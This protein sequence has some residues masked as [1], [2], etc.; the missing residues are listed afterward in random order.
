MT[1]ARN[2]VV[3]SGSLAILL[4]S[5]PRTVR[6]MNHPKRRIVATIAGLGLVLG[7]QVALGPSPAAAATTL[8]VSTTADIAVN[9]GACGN[10]GTTTAP[11]PLSLREAT[12][13][14]NN[15]GGTVTITIPSGTYVL[16]HGELQVGVHAGQ[17][18][19]LDGTTAATTTISAGG[20][21]RVLDFDP[22][23]AGG[24]GGTVSDLTITGGVD[25]T[26]GGAGIIA[27]SG[28]TASADTLAI[29][30]SVITANHANN[31]GPTITNRPGGGVQFIG[32][33]LTISNSTISNNS[34]LSS[35]G[36]GVAYAGTGAT[37][38]EAL[39]VTNT[40]FSDNSAT[41]TN[42]TSITNGGALDIR[43]AP[44]TQAVI[45]G[46]RFTNN[47]V[48]ATTGGAVGAAIRH[49]SGAL[50][51]TGSTFT[52]NTVNGG[53]APPAGGAI[54]VTTGTATLH[55]NRFV[56][57]TATSGAAVDVGS[58]AGAVDAS[59]NWFGCNAAPSVSGCDSVAGS[60]V[61][62]PRLA[63]T[64]TANPSTVFGPG[65]TSTITAS[66]TTDSLGGAVPSANLAA[67][68]DLTVG[69][70]DP[71]PNGATVNGVLVSTQ[72]TISSG[73]SSVT[74]G[75]QGS[76][77]VG[78]VVATL[79]GGSSTVPV[80]VD[81]AP[82]VTL[83]PSDQAVQPGDPVSFTAAGTGFPTPTVKWQRSVDGGTNFTDI[84]S[85]TSTTYSFT[86]AA[87]DSG[88]RYRAL[89]TNVTDISRTATST[90]ATLTVQQPPSF[91]SATTAT[92]VTGTAGSFTI[93]T[94]GQPTVSAITKTGSLPSGLAFTDNGNGTATV[95]GTPA[96]NTGGTYPLGLT[97]VNGVAPAGTQSLA[98]Q[99][100]QAPA[101]TGNPS[102]QLVNPGTPVS[103]TAA[104]TGVPTPT[105][106]WQ[107]S[108]DGGSSY[109]N[110]AGATSATYS[111]T[112]TS[113]DSG[114]RYRAVFTNVV[115]TATSTAALLQ[116][117]SAPAFTSENVATF[118]V[119]VAGSFAITT[120]G[121]PSA[122]L[123][124]VGT[125]PA[126]LTLADNGDGTATLTGTPP[127]GSGG[128]YTFT[129]KAAN[130]FSP[131]ASQT[132]TLSVDESPTITSADNVTFTVG[133]AGTFAV[134]TTAGF[135]TATAI[136]K[137]GAL[138]S[139]VTLVDNH[140]GTA[141]LAGTPSAG[142]SGSYPI[143]VSAAAVGGLT[144]ATTQS[145]T[146]TVL[147]PPTITSADHATFAV[148]SDGTF[149]VQTTPGNPNATTL[150]TTG[151]LPSG[152][153][154]VDNGDG[155][156]TLS[157]TPAT[158]TGNSYPITI[159]AENS[160][161]SSTQ[162][163]TL[164]V[165][166]LPT[167][168]SADHTTVTVGTSATF[169][170]STVPGFPAATAMT[171][172]GTLPAGLTFTDL[173]GGSATLSGTPAAGS[174]GSYALTLTATNSAGHTDQSFVLTVH[175]SPVIT[176]PDHTTFTVGSPGSFTVTTGVGYPVP[177]SLS[178]TG[179]LPS[180]VTFTDN[181]DGT[182]TLAGT[183]A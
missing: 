59:E 109:S 148:G 160:A 183:P 163:F 121:V 134:T 40:T 13:L 82:A 42:G 33:T 161:T 80:T 181:E 68:N 154:F 16:T 86:A 35:P 129:L 116:V 166:D 95:A 149:T 43:G 167:F 30:N 1:A 142:T 176:S 77:G 26:F 155:S 88:N 126:W 22:N 90:A 117:G 174:G 60:L 64:T 41:N 81:R 19:T 102:D 162:V 120:S 175:E 168:A 122:T 85:A 124:S 14:A 3:S 52:G 83:N 152:V 46:S 115:S 27:G 110:I 138:P 70:S 71:L 24:V 20:G 105:V 111:F 76:S 58:G 106:Q 34:S 51:V 36:S 119:G 151:A 98:V 100:N 84:A 66:L 93:T 11:S 18:V 125:V 57:N 6:P 180:G 156:A 158:G 15:I 157:G 114:N 104:A 45:T 113:A 29:S 55:Y 128:A 141:T 146:L 53:A 89:F 7:A 94:S 5:D 12:C 79:D 173:G 133:N 21:S 177:P 169:P 28:S 75:S 171:E 144:A 97:A 31:A 165:T 107:R 178:E 49:E 179:S 143:V 164:T 170:I 137:S 131:S 78:H 39:T 69:W 172:S 56:G 91:T 62:S 130:G 10:A 118:T 54:E 23:L 135:P 9:A 112:A 44:T 2:R 127:A 103:F 150:S 72:T 92:F 47:S 132:F 108:T 139:G 145:F 48:V 37:A 159:L 147:G 153:T 38:G 50:T 67:F 63:L 136:T 140:D 73:Q 25:S 87:A 32:G 61:V 96:A 17:N 8:V 99:V 123:S 65:A 101:V 74:Y 182:A 4:L